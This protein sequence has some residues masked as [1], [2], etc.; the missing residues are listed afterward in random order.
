MIEPLVEEFRYYD[1]TQERNSTVLTA[2]ET[3]LREIAI[4]FGADPSVAAQDAKDFV[5]LKIEIFKLK[6]SIFHINQ[7][8]EVI[9][10][11]LDK[12]YSNTSFTWLGLPQAITAL[13]RSV[14]ISL[15]NDEKI[16]IHDPSKAN[17]FDKLK[18]ILENKTE[19]EIR[20]LFGFHYAM[21]KS[22]FKERVKEIKAKYFKVGPTDTMKKT[23]GLRV[24]K[25]IVVV[26]VIVVAVV[27]VVVVVVVVAAAIV[28]VV[29]VVV[30]V[31]GV[32]VVVVVVIVVVTMFRIKLPIP[33]TSERCQEE[34]RASFFK[35][36]SK[37]YVRRA[38]SETTK[39]TL[40]AMHDK[41]KK[42]FRDAHYNTTWMGNKTRQNVLF[43]LEKLSLQN[44]LPEH[45]FDDES[46]EEEYKDM[47]LSPKNYFKNRDTIQYHK[48]KRDLKKLRKPLLSVE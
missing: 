24:H 15:R 20:N 38:V 19:R 27:A 5:D 2:Y 41:I 48:L 25:E 21:S 30:V 8:F 6:T 39:P 47:M 4:E 28:L 23:N 40:S 33:P 45:G 14:N 35:I 42:S 34:T 12:L 3:L 17:T 7:P 37:E 18:E 1:Y 10:T 13:F 29:V 11:T 36:I 32:V 26:V 43:K 9:S 16:F 22:F 31:K 44:I 46:L